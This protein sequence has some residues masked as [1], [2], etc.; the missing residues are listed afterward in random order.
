VSLDRH[1]WHFGGVGQHEIGRG[2][3]LAPGGILNPIT[4]SRTG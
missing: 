2:A 4:S 3:T 1:E